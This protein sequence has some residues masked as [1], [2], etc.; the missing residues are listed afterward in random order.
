M[1]ALSLFRAFPAYYALRSDFVKS[2][3]QSAQMKFDHPMADSS[4]LFPAGS[5]E[6][7]LTYRLTV[8]LAVHFLHLNEPELL[9]VDALA[10]IALLFLVLLVAF[11]ASGSKRVALFVC[12][13]TACSWSGATAFHELRGGYYDA[14][15]LC[16]MTAAFAAPST[17][18]TALLLFL[19]A[20]TDER[21]LVAAPF[22]VLCSERGKRA[23]VIFAVAGY[24][25]LRVGLTALYSYPAGP[26][27]VGWSVLISQAREIPL[28]LW[29][30]I[31]GCWILMVFAII[32]LFGRRRPWI[33]LAF[34]SALAVSAVGGL[35]VVD[36][37][38]GIAF[39]LPAVLAALV[40]LSRGES[41]VRVER[42]AAVSALA[43][44]LIPPFY[45]E[46]ATGMWWLSP[47]PMQ[48]AHWLG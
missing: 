14:V 37:T 33:A 22:L 35:A 12:V 44:L 25:S 4:H 1:L 47:L 6:S 17:T 45:L 11:A 31:G 19:A 16:L 42:I 40:L 5:H 20:W 2:T 9:V 29:S 28:A 38:R 26:T 10:G 43:S 15:A 27:A 21:A 48:V 39:C 34:C 41:T 8:P 3:W 30:G 24:V 46:G 36:M 18:L 23:A 32:G 13:A 7:N